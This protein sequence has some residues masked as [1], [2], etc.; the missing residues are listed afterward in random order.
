EQAAH[1]AIRAFLL[2]PDSATRV[3][4]LAALRPDED[5]TAVVGVELRDRTGARLLEYGAGVPAGAAAPDAELTSLLD[6][7]SAA[8]GPLRTV[9]GQAVFPVVAGLVE[10]GERLGSVVRWQ[11][12]AG[13]QIVTSGAGVFLAN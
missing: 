6:T 13:S 4:A 12:L 3:G 5:E 10:A 8:V 7:E 2:A 1:G 9:E 11:T